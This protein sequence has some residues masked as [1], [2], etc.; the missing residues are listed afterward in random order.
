[1]DKKQAKVRIEKLKKVINHHRYFY[2]VLDRQEIS[3]AALD[4]LKNELSNLEKKFPEFITPDSPTQRVGGEA[5]EKFEKAEHREPMLSINDVFSDE[6]I[7]DW[8]AYLGRLVP[9]IK[10][11]YFCEMKMDGFAISLLYKNGMLVRAATRGNGL[12]GE[13]VTENI[14]TIESIPLSI[15]KSGE[16]EVRGEVYMD[17]KTFKRIN[18]DQKKKGEKEYA[19]PRNL[20]AGSVRQLDPQL[21]ASRGL[22]FMAYDILGD[23]SQKK[24]SE[25]HDIA[26]DMGFP[27]DPY[28]V[29]CKNTKEILDFWGAL[30][31]RR[32]NL[33]HNIDGVVISVNDNDI[34]RKLGVAGK[35][36]R[37]MRALKFAARQAT[38]V[39]EDIQVHIGRTGA[40]T[41]I[42]HLKHVNIEGITVR[43]ATL[44]NQDEV[45]RLD[46]KIGDTVIVER[47]GDV[48]P[49]VVSVVKELRT[50]KEKRFKLP[51]KCPTCGTKLS[52]TEKVILRC[53]NKNCPARFRE[54][55]Y[56]FVSKNAFDI[57]GVGPKIIDALVEN[58]LVSKPQDIF[59]VKEGDLM[60]LDGF[61]EKS[62]E[63][64]VKSIN[65]SKNI[66]LV[67][68]IRALGIRHVG[69]ET[70]SDLAQYF[71][72]LEKLKAASVDDIRNIPDIG[73]VVTNE[74]YEWFHDSYN[75][76]FVKELV[77]RGVKIQKSERTGTKLKGLTFVFT[78]TLENITRQEAERS[79]KMLGGDTSGSVS[80]AT[81]YVVV[82]ENPGSKYDKA[83]KLG[84]KIITESEF[85]K[86][87]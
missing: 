58:G 44:H 16:I 43:R 72:S 23:L 84:V 50:G 10:I 45:D 49:D 27:T 25:E 20:A 9:G 87:I 76:N 82:G 26:K 79:V 86:M 74:I 47:A 78:G 56:F 31:N 29:I 36:P 53:T 34:F 65:D 22:K 11:E 38:T 54:Y 1:M 15:K 39:V 3:D 67:H 33:P 71:G 35:S 12:I 48:I 85:L 2:H 17:K 19:N 37:G 4:S 14:K 42:A 32:E 8:E 46:V 68:F 66:S 61:Q 57:E 70:A 7:E 64:I 28:A 55:L 77:S 80:Q 59:D 21:T 5:L 41:P 62:A 24:H 75:T 69:A 18:K 52:K 60:P 63:S 81:D 40:V 51:F 83:E 13:D 73:E 30:S 6:E